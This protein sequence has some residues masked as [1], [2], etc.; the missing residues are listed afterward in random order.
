MGQ[1]AEALDRRMALAQAAAR[2]FER[3]EPDQERDADGR[4]VCA[5]CG[6]RIPAARLAALPRAVR[7]RGCQEDA[8]EAM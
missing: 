7:C 4:V 8:E 2:R 1:E 6:E 5:D 3:Q